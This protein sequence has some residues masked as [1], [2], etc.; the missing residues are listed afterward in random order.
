MS[1]SDFSNTGLIRGNHGN[2]SDGK[3]KLRPRFL[4]MQFIAA[5]FV[6]ILAVLLVSNNSISYTKQE[7]TLSLIGSGT[8]LTAPVKPE[9]NCLV[10]FEDGDMLSEKAIDAFEQMFSQMRV[11]YVMTECREFETDCLA[12]LKKLVIAIT[13]LD[14]LGEKIFDI[15]DWVKGGGC[16]MIAYP[17]E[18]N[19]ALSLIAP[20]LGI[21]A[22]GNDM[23]V[24]SKLHFS[25][26]FLIGGAADDFVVTDPYDSMLTVMLSD[27]CRVYASS[28]GDNPIPAVWSYELGSGQ[29]VVDNI[30]FF[31][32]AYRGIH[33]AAYSLLGD[34]FAWPVINAAVFYIDDFPS[35]V[36]G[37]EGK[38]IT[39][40]YGMDI[41]TFY[42]MVWWENV[43]SFTN[44][45]GVRYTG[46]VIEHYSDDVEAP[47]DRNRDITRYQYF[48]NMLLDNGGEIGFHGYNHMPLCLKNFD[49]QGQYD[50]YKRWESYDDMQKGLS[51]LNRFCSEVFPDEE[52]HTYVPPSNILSEEG[53]QML[54]RDFPEIKA[55]A[56]VYLE[57]GLAYV[58]D[59]RVSEDG[60]VET[61]RV[62]SGYI[63]DDFT[64]LTA[65]CELNFH[66]VSS[67][68]QHPDDVLDEDRGAAM[69]WP[70]LYENISAYMQWL[71]SSAKDIR[72]LTGV[73]MA[74]AVQRYDSLTVDQRT[75]DDRL[76]ISLGGFADEAWLL[77]R[78]NEGMP[79]KVTGGELT[80]QINGLYLLR[81]DSPEVVIEIVR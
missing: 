40:D 9:T 35:P 48:G 34:S 51:E 4:R 75:V 42:T 30:G 16:L 23:S 73:E 17:P 67:H 70:K 49:Y 7:R 21:Q 28:V 76:I 38:Y 10:L 14:L 57:G 79:G 11:E 22:I 74:G 59:F 80:R 8:E 15:M 61:P 41:E 71:Y 3:R 53:R 1:V 50:S 44:K 37:G 26:D 25:D 19:G 39:R 69:G 36:P 5:A 13:R 43:R 52:F 55:I 63:M 46:L 24:L 72:N 66:F 81:A 6:L 45:Y 62:I 29:V 64:K 56:S 60:I 58:Q 77:V 18:I 65:L 2:K 20:E 54:R 32:K 33:C 47:Y 78:I 68:F 27:A 12:N 31:D